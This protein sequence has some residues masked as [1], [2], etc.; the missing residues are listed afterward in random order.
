M[1][2]DLPGPNIP[3]RITLLQMSN[4]EVVRYDLMKKERIVIGTAISGH[5]IFDFGKTPATMEHFRKL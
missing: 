5:F 1:K 4:W 3:L 2:F